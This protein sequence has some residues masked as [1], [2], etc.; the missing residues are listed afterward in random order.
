MASELSWTLSANDRFTSLPCEAVVVCLFEAYA[1]AQWLI[2]NPSP[3]PFLPQARGLENYFSVSSWGKV[4]LRAQN[5]H[6]RAEKWQVCLRCGRL[7]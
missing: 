4:P 7:A 5:P 3:P 6:P 1:R 2:P